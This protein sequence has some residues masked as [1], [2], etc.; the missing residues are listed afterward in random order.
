MSG[1]VR[2]DVTRIAPKL[3][4]GSAPPC[5]KTLREHGFDTVVLCASEYQPRETAFPGVKVIRAPFHDEK[6][7]P[8]A[9][10]TAKEAAR[11]VVY[12]IERGRRVLVTCYAGRNRSGLVVARALSKLSG[13]PA[14]LVVDHVQ[15]LREGALSNITFVQNIYAGVSR[16]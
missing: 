6:I 2:L 16:A 11:Q 15:R 12:E 14:H 10:A 9:E 13:A 3:W 5:G 8:A 4:I 1:Y 7:T